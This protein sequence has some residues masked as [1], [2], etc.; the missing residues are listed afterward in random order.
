VQDT[1]WT[2]R[3][4]GAIDKLENLTFLPKEG[5]VVGEWRREEARRILEVLERPED[6][7]HGQKY[8]YWPG[9]NSNT[10]ATWV[11]RQSGIRI[12]HHPLAVG[13]DYMGFW[14]FGAWTTT[15]RTGLQVESPILGVKLGLLDGLELHLLCMTLGIDIWPP[16]IKTPLGRFG[17]VE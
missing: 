12:D 13:K 16:A 2:S 8:R 15:T 3:K 1:E 6:Y 4:W 7:P 10:Y 9:P 14:G 5:K 11:L 17:V